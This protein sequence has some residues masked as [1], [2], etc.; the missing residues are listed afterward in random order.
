[1]FSII[2]PTYNR[3][4]TLDR[5]YRSL[6]EQ[7][8]K[9]FH[10][11]IVDDA[12]TDNTKELVEKYMS[13]DNG[14][15]IEYHLM[16]YN[17]GK[18]AALNYGFEFCTEPYTIIADSDDSFLPNTI[19][20]LTEIWERVNTMINGD[21]IAT[22]WTLV[23]DEE[24][25]VVGEYFP[26]DFWQTNIK[27]RLLKRNLPVEGEK[28]HSWRTE[29]LR[30]YKMFSHEMCHI[31]ESAT[32]HRINLDYDFLHLNIVHR[33]YYRSE[34][35]LINKKRSKIKS[36]LAK[37]YTAYHQLVAVKP[38]DIIRYGYYHG[39]AF[40]YCFSSIVLRFKEKGLGFP[41]RL[42]C[43]FIFIYLLPFVILGKK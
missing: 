18:P 22:V 9:S 20:D 24:H 17:Q 40:N 39:L 30:K 10:W 37:Y 3:A 8:K 35:G 1:M 14:F 12:S 32:W 7:T 28:W 38:F 23:E 11:V 31:G 6:C 15:K 36:A 27:D 26:Y 19:S 29:V 25:N 13:V 21:K 16:P 42:I 5:V 4:H 2:T 34:D 41:K 43:F 33:M